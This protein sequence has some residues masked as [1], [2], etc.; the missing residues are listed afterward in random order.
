[1]P[2]K[3]DLHNEMEMDHLMVA[4]AE[5][6]HPRLSPVPLE[7][8]GLQELTARIHMDKLSGCFRQRLGGKLQ[9]QLAQCQARVWA[10]LPRSAEI[11]NT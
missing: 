6:P 1:M 11:L 2:T 10:S 8:E 7:T 4:A 5:E 9:L 3:T